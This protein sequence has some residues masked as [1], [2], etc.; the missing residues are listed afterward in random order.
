MTPERK[1][2]LDGDQGDNY[3]FH[4]V[5]RLLIRTFGQGKSGFF[6]A[7][8]SAKKTRSSRKVSEEGDTHLCQEILEDPVHFLSVRDPFVDR[9]HA[10]LDFKQLP[11]VL[12]VL[13]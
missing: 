1:H 13:W 4:V 9:P 6:S 11:G 2:D 12:E 10:L 8:S 5:R 7:R 3:D